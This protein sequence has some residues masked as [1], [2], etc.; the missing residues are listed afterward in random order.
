MVPVLRNYL[1]CS[2]VDMTRQARFRA[3]AARG[4]CRTAGNPDLGAENPGSG[5]SR[6]HPRRRTEGLIVSVVDD[7]VAHVCA[8]RATE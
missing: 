1:E 3:L 7:H 8:A 5:G 6:A 2:R 4:T